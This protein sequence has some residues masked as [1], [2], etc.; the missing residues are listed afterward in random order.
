MKRLSSRERIG[1]IIL[2]IMSAGVVGLSEWGARG[3]S[4]A[5][6]HV[7]KETLKAVILPT[8]DEEEVDG[9][10]TITNKKKEKHKKS[11]KNNSSR[12][13]S[14]NNTEASAKKGGKKSGKSAIRQTPQRRNPLDEPI[15]MKGQD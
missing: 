15:P 2:A 6:A 14:R 7:D 12:R 5:P 13:K 9:S 4:R 10:D 11:K 1:L 8:P 3:C